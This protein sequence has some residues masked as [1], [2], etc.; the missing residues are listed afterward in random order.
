MKLTTKTRYGMR[1]I[2]ELA[3]RHNNGPVSVSNIAKKEGI[4]IT[5]L[6]QLLNK[7]KKSGIVKSIRG[8]RG[9][10]I[11]SKDPKDVTVFDVVKVLEGDLSVVFCMSENAKK[12]CDKTQNCMTKYV[13]HKLN[14]SIRDV[15]ESIT[16]EDLCRKFAK[17]EFKDKHKF[18]YSI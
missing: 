9:G 4:S 7:L 3:M 13:W 16:L 2:T 1:A 8:L 15:L 10:Y 18:H 12:K 6:G 5:Y 11:L 17:K 14:D